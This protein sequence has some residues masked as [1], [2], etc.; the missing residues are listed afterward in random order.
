MA[1]TPAEALTAVNKIGD[2]LERARSQ[3]FLILGPAGVDKL[4]KQTQPAE[5][6]DDQVASAFAVLKSQSAVHVG[7]FHEKYR[8]LQNERSVNAAAARAF[9]GSDEVILR[10]LTKAKRVEAAAKK[11]DAAAKKKLDAA[12]AAREKTASAVELAH[13][14]TIRLQKSL[15]SNAKEKP[16]SYTH[17]TLPTKA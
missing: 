9:D 5:T 14:E 6:V 8:H 15:E 7:E 1:D 10:D 11:K 16:V 3:N 12:Q 13:A 2:L 17:L 4:L